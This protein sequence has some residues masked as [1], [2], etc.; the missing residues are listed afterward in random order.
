MTKRDALKDDIV[1]TVLRAG[2]AI[3]A[4]KIANR[5]AVPEDAT[6]QKLLDELVAE[7]RLVARFTLLTNGDRAQLYNVRTQ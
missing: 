7:G 6:L 1:D 4:E 3:R 5:V 2:I